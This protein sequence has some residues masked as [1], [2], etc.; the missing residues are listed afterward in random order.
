MARARCASRR[1][2]SGQHDLSAFEVEAVFILEV[3]LTTFVDTEQVRMYKFQ[4]L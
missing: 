2:W 4:G 1:N 3:L